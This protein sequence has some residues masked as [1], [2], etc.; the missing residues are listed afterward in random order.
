MKVLGSPSP[1]CRAPP[2]A[3][4]AKF[5]GVEAKRGPAPGSRPDGWD[6]PLSAS[7]VCSTQPDTVQ[8][9]RMPSSFFF[10]TLDAPMGI[11]QGDAS[12]LKK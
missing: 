9:D 8:G 2:G 10:I 5:Q 11:F 12:G 3:G 6:G 4:Y 7:R 1:R